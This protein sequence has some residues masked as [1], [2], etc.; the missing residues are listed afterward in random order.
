LATGALLRT[1]GVQSEAVAARLRGYPGI[2]GVA[3]RLA[4]LDYFERTIAESIYISAGIVIFAAVVIA[5]GVVYNGSRIAL[6]E[7]GRELATLRVLGFTRGEVSAMFLG[8]QGVLTLTA[9]PFG[10]A[11]GFGIA[12]VLA[13]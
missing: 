11:A 13:N 10:A 4:L 3:S 7:R 9:L 2:S 6:S 5:A 12:A 1:G 8:E